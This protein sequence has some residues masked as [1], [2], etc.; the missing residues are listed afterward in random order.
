MK[1]FLC[2]SG[3]RSKAVAEALGHWIGQVIQA[4]QPWISTQTDKGARW[5]QE[6]GDHLEEASVGIVCLTPENLDATWIHFEAGALSKTKDAK[7]CTFLLG[8]QPTDIKEPLAQ[9]QATKAEETEIRALIQNINRY[10]GEGGERAL[11]EKDVDEIFDLHW[12]RLKEKLKAISDQKISTEPVRQDS[13]KLD[14]ILEV[15]RNQERRMQQ[16]ESNQSGL[17]LLPPGT[18]VGSTNVE[19]FFTAARSAPVSAKIATGETVTVTPRTI[20]PR[21]R[22]LKVKFPEEEEDDTKPKD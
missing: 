3:D 11:P 14:E 7:V 16:L 22:G 18:L 5:R 20:P 8:M 15:V 4:I 9:F 10:V 13:E 6:V 12:P 19:P 1:V 2:W 21:F 17:F